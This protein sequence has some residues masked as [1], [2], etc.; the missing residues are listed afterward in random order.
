[1]TENFKEIT[2]TSN[3]KVGWKI[4]ILTQISGWM[5]K[6]TTGFATENMFNLNTNSYQT[7]NTTKQE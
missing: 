6:P 7:F 5:Q 4:K 3:H 1:M 2:V